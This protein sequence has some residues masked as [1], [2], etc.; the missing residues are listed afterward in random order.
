MLSKLSEQ[1]VYTVAQ[2]RLIE[3]DILAAIVGQQEA[4]RLKQLAMG[5][6][7]VVFRPVIS[8][9]TRVG[10]QMLQQTVVLQ[11]APT[12][13]LLFKQIVSTLM[14]NIKRQYVERYTEAQ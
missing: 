1:N 7:M 2:I 13:V 3:L 11:D 14:K 10:I 5:K 4:A 12:D 9:L 6:D 8:S